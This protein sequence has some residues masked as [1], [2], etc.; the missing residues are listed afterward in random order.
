MF[1]NEENKI[2]KRQHIKNVPIMNNT[3]MYSIYFLGNITLW[4][5]SLLLT[6]MQDWSKSNLWLMKLFEYRLTDWLLHLYHTDL[7]TA[8]PSSVP[9]S[10]IMKRQISAHEIACYNKQTTNNAL[11][12]FVS[13]FSNAIL[14][15][16]WDNT[17]NSK[18]LIHAKHVLK[19]T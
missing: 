9:A 8:W 13:S 10:D 16:M 14:L 6:V 2:L 11:L 1:Q 3:V 17:T 7:Q 5:V 15:Q 4:K 18:S 12:W 19:C